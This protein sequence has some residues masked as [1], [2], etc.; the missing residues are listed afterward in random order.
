ME[1]EI[2]SSG[3]LI[4]KLQQVTLRGGG[5]QPYHGARIDLVTLDPVILAPTQRYVLTTELKKIEQVRWGILKDYNKDI[6]NL[7]GYVKCTYEK[8]EP[9]YEVGKLDP[10]DYLVPEK[11]IDVIP[12]VV[13]EYIDPKG[14]LHLIIADGQHRCYLAYTTGQFVTVAYVRGI[15]W[16]YP[17]YAYPLPNGWDDVEV[18]DD[19]PEGYI[20]KFHVAKEHKKLYRDFNS[21][22]ENIG[23]SRPY[24]KK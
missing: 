8:S 5:I 1:L 20:K 10:V 17:Y 16:G 11:T 24:D 7:D 4:S 2:R 19:I 9:I 6:L 14:M 22:F 15:H 12:P 3:E 13:E 23:D 18:R 21:Q